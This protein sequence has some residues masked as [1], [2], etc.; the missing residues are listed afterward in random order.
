MGIG[1]RTIAGREAEERKAERVAM[2]G[3]ERD[4]KTG[5][6][7]ETRRTRCAAVE[8]SARARVRETRDGQTDGREER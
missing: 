6:E 7:E 4:A 3:S 1:L 2:R 5:E 8:E